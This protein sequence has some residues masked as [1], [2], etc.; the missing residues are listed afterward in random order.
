MAST[1][2][3]PE[4]LS[5]T[6]CDARISGLHRGATPFEIE[7]NI[8]K[9]SGQSS[10]F[11]YIVTLPGRLHRC[12]AYV[13]VTD[14][15]IAHRLAEL[16]E[17]PRPGLYQVEQHPDAE[18]IAEITTYDRYIPE[19][20][21]R[22]YILLVLYHHREHHGQIQVPSDLSGQR[23]SPIDSVATSSHPQGLQR[24]A[25]RESMELRKRQRVPDKG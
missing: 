15:G 20:D 2:Q 3:Q 18:C 5:G 24:V 7:N 25:R 11:R 13:E 19:T 23:L 6:V 21:V 4:P 9:P 17:F 12:H 8:L 14:P 1:Q 22:V 10:S 16:P